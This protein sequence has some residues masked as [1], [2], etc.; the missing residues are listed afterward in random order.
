MQKVKIPLTVDPVKSAQKRLDY[1]GI[2]A[3]QQL[4]RLNEATKGVI[5]DA[6]VT[7]SF[8]TDIQKLKT[9]RGRVTVDVNLECQRCWKDFPY[10]CDIEFIYS[11]IF[12]E[13]Q[14]DHLPDAYEPTLVDENG[15][16]DL[17]Q[18]IEDELLLSLPQVPMHDPKA[19]HYNEDNMVFGEIPLADERPNPFSVLKNVK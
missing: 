5:N 4:V 12:S 11:P 19:C 1:N 6:E 2:I 7:L 3:I 10:H 13:E 17:L 16:I 18:L 8:D 15:E 14:M 9:I